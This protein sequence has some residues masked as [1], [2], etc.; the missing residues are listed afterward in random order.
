MKK[1]SKY[2][3]IGTL[4]LFKPDY[5]SENKKTLLTSNIIK[6]YLRKRKGKYYYKVNFI[7]NRFN[8]KIKENSDLI[9]LYMILSENYISLKIV[10]I[11]NKSKTKIMVL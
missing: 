1:N 5:L 8:I 6:E 3:K 9:N 7:K 11:F 10:F 2:N 4:H